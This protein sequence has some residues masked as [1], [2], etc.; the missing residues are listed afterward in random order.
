[1]RKHILSISYDKSL[2]IT[3]QLLLEQAGFDVTSA[4]YAGKGFCKLL[5]KNSLFLLNLRKFYN[6]VQ[7]QV[8]GHLGQPCGKPGF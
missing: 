4:F 3:R 5:K 7:D 6:P 2:L 8:V 1:M